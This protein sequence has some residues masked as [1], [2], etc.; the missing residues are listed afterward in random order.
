[1]KSRML[2]CGIA[3]VGA[4]LLVNQV[5]SRAEN[6]SQEAKKQ[7]AQKGQPGGE[8]D[9]QMAAWMKLAAPGEFHEH[10]KPLAGKW[11]QVVR[12]RMAP[13]APWEESKGVSTYTWVL[14]NRFLR[15]EVGGEMGG[16]PFEGL[17]YLGYDNFKKKY[18]SVWMDNMGTMMMFGEGTC[19]AAGK[20]IT[21]TGEYDDPMT[22]GKKKSKSVLRIGDDKHVYEMYSYGPDGKEFLSL[23]ITYTRA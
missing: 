12:W 6:P 5:A 20:V 11:T 13:E 9:A 15:Q 16:Q 3:C 4:L 17:G 23:E 14:G 22:G 7:E 10:L 18:V 21:T 8:M 19:D 2:W 1:M